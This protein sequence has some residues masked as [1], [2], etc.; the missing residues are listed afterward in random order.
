MIDA[1]KILIIKDRMR[2]EDVVGAFFDLKKS[3]IEY[4]C[5][6]P[7]HGTDITGRSRFRHAKT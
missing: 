6:C 4:T 5:L 1:N 2:I 7:F 3:G